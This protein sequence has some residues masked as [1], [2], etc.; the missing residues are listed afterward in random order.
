M[1]TVK[2]NN[3]CSSYT[4]LKDGRRSHYY[5][6]V[7]ILFSL[8]C[9][10]DLRIT[11]RRPPPPPPRPSR[12]ETIV[13][14]AFLFRTRTAFEHVAFTLYIILL[15]L[16]HF[17]TRKLHN[18]IMR[19]KCCYSFSRVTAYCVRTVRVYIYMY[20]RGDEYSAQRV[21]GLPTRRPRHPENSKRTHYLSLFLSL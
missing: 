5:N 16:F 17:R 7:I 20:V 18:N 21:C 15:L 19:S 9:T 14:F 11:A 8:H 3:N 13:F 2:S 4:P 12:L 6:T 10:C 1:C